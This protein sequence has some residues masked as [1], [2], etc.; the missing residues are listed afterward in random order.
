MQLCMVVSVNAETQGVISELARKELERRE[1]AVQEGQMLLLKGDEAYEAG[2]YEEAAEAYAGAMQSFPEAPATGELRMAAR[3]RHA[4][5]TVEWAKELTRKGDVQ[6]AKDVVDKILVEGVAL[7]DPLVEGYRV[8]LDDPVRT[9]PALTKEHAAKVDEVRRHFYMAQGSFD[10]GKYDEAER[11]YKEILKIDPYNKA[12]RRGLEKTA[13]QKVGYYQAAQDEMRATLL[14]EVDGAWELPLAP[15][16]VE[17]DLPSVEEMNDLG[18]FIPMQNKLDL[19]V[20]PSF[21]LEEGTLLEAIELLKLRA[22]ESDTVTQNEK[23]KG[24]NIAVNLGDTASGIGGQI[25]AKK[26]DLRLSNVPVKQILKYITEITGTVYRIED[27]AVTIV[28]VGTGGDVLISRTYRVPPDF[29]SILTAGL[30]AEE[31]PVDIFNTDAGAGGGLLA[32][33]MSIQEALSRQ[34]VL[35]PRGASVV[36][37]ASNMLRV[38]NTADNQDVI[39]QIIDNMVQV[40]PVAVAVR[41]TMLRIQEDVLKELS[42]DWMLDTFQFGG[43]SWIPGASKLNLTG[44][45][46]GS[47]NPITDIAALP[48]TIFPTNPITAG[49]RSGDFATPENSIDRLISEAGNRDAQQSFRAPGVFGVNGIVGGATIQALMRGLDQKKGFDL[50]A[51]PSVTTRSGQ[52]ASIFLIDEFIYP[53]EYE[54]PEIPTNVSGNTTVQIDGGGNIVGVD[55]TAVNIPVIPAMPTAFETRDI[56]IVLEVLPVADEKKQYV[57]VSLNPSF[58]EFDGFVNYG[59]P[60]GTIT[61]GVA[62]PLRN[63]LAENEILMPIFSV[64]KTSTNL[65]VADGATIVIGGLLKEEVTNVNDKTPILGDIPL[66]DRLFK[67]EAKKHVSTAIIFFVNVELLDPTGRPYRDR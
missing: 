54:P 59:S 2:R 47:G 3:Q 32:K 30:S 42:F 40:E 60:I 17:L 57:N 28:P 35:F 9:N 63:I 44:G 1:A 62:G 50:M 58:S 16:L 67:S 14:G 25:A 41:V 31:E 38:I 61:E 21:Q 19:I 51:Q 64:Q 55:T 43:D 23:D 6:G 56:G 65:V 5:A 24:I 66:V 26:F 36:L 49:N 15:D 45:T 13:G 4:Q 29:Q 22:E 12:A 39:A 37:N 53:T 27:Y 18:G 11:Y 52:A 10:L 48:G 8:Q 46:T 7:G 33:R 34:G 20:I